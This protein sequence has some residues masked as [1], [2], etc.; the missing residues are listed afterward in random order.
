MAGR[1]ITS[2]YNT[3]VTL[4]TTADNPVTIVSTAQLEAGLQGS[5]S[6]AW[7]VDNLGTIS[8]NFAI[9]LANASIVTNSGSVLQSD[10]MGVAV[11]LGTGGS[12][13]NT[14]L[15]SVSG[16]ASNGVYFKGAGSLTNTGIIS[17]TNVDTFGVRLRAAG[18]I[19]NS[20]TGLISAFVGV[21]ATSTT[22]ALTITN[23]GSGT[24]SAV[25]G[26]ALDLEG[27]GTL[28]NDGSIIGR[29]GVRDEAATAVTVT[30]AGYIGSNYAKNLV[31]L[32]LGTGANRVI[33]DPGARFV[34]A[35][36]GGG[37]AA[38]ELAG[39]SAATLGSF[40]PQFYGFDAL[41][42]D[43]NA[44]WTVDATDTVGSGVA[45]SVYGNLT[46]TGTI[47]TT[48]TLAGF[49]SYFH[50]L[51]GGT[52]A[53]SSHAVYSSAAALVELVNA[54]VLSGQNVAVELL[55]AGLVN[56]LGSATIV[57]SAGLT[58]P[59]AAI[60]NGGLIKGTSAGFLYGA[61]L[62]ENGGTLTNAATG[63]ITSAGFGILIG[64]PLSSTAGG[65]ST[66][67]NGGS[68]EGS[69]FALELGISANSLLVIEPGAT[70]VGAVVGA[71]SL[72]SHYSNELELASAAGTGTLNGLGPTYRNFNRVTVD[73]GA[74]WAFAGSNTVVSGATLT[75]SGT[76]AAGALV[77]NGVILV[78]P[79][80]MK[81][82]LTGTGSVTIGS[83]STLE[84]FGT[85]AAGQTI[86][87][88]G[89]SD[90]LQIDSLTDF[91]GTITGF[92]ATD[93]IDVQGIGLAKSARIGNF[94]NTHALNLYSGTNGA[95]TK[96]FS[97]P[98]ITSITGGEG[99]VASGLHF[100]A[101]TNNG[102]LIACYLRGT[103]IRTARG[104]VAIEFLSVGDLVETLTGV[105]EPIRWIGRRRTMLAATAGHAA[106]LPVLIRAGAIAEGLPR[107][108]LCVSPE[109]ALCIDGVLAPARHLVNGKSIV[110]RRD[111]E[112]V[113]YFHLELAEHAVIFAE[114]MPAETFVDCDSR[115]MF[116]NAASYAGGGA[117]AWRFCAPRMEE[118]EGLEDIRTRINGRAGIA[119]G[120]ELG[121]LVGHLERVTAGAVEGW[122]QDARAPERPVWLELIADGAIAAFVLANRHRNDLEAAGLGSGRHAFR[123]ALA[124]QPRC[125][126]ARRVEDGAL[127]GSL[128]TSSNAA[129]LPVS[130]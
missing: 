129:R 85:V 66:V 33:I 110:R 84:V 77:N 121:P 29:S 87:M 119:Y 116:D 54:G 60:Y 10:S 39:T 69:T 44:N 118:G 53:S 74:N 17:G 90:F 82:G 104:E 79:A 38:L 46:N 86:V 56:N 108:D 101:D 3:L 76:L 125:V 31:A 97:F 23:Q 88:T 14:N 61:V 19:D 114:G 6:Y 27:G 35:V 52:V 93:V 120:D 124:R 106:V 117:P 48:V 22:D 55:K 36:N 67:V 7:V 28:V 83:N 40:G 70:F 26:A 63:T 89:A 99:V 122:A 130:R 103:R 8:G 126:E 62:L 59:T 1:T 127:L 20:G 9:F 43:A 2:N 100:A 71:P 75:D 98:F 112:V 25:N 113:E 12:V 107:R 123:V 95:G 105:L 11:Y 49:G 4:T 30:N 18:S 5:A 91:S 78:D 92:T 94:P 45:L 15:I 50:N 24:F 21:Y 65:G 128:T 81:V 16:F 73:A 72:S 47:D 102:T 32:N 34:G 109:H 51:S 13:D 57:E 115:G 111:L 80:R 41:G 96:L 42:V 37:S 58:A 68:I 64:N